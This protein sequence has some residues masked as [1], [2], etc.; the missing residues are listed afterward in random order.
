MYVN[1]FHQC[2]TKNYC[3]FLRDFSSS[4]TVPK[5]NYTVQTVFSTP[6]YIL[7]SHFDFKKEVSRPGGLLLVQK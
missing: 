3:A 1:L 7:H 6:F 2:R 4:V 5:Q